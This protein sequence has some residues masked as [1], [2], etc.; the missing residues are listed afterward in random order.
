[1]TM[2]VH[3]LRGVTLVAMLAAL[4]VAPSVF[5]DFGADL[6]FLQK[7]TNVIVLG[8]AAGQAKLAVAPAWQGRVMTSTASGKAGTS[9]GWIN[10]ELIASGN[11]LPHINVFGGEDRYWIGPEGGQFSVFFVKGS[12]FDLDHWQTPLPVDTEPWAVVSQTNTSATF[13]AQFSLANFSG[14]K[15][16][17][18]ADREVRLLAPADAWKKFGLQPN[19]RVTLVAY[20]SENQ[21]TNVGL[22]PWIKET[23]LLSI[24]IL[25]QYNPST[26]TT[27]AIPI[28]SGPDSS[29]GPKVTT[30]YFGSIPPD[31]LIVKD[32]AIF[33]SGDGQYRSK[34]GINPRRSKGIIGSYDATG[35]ILTLAQFTQPARASDYVNSLWKIQDQPYGGD[36]AM[37][38]NDGPS[39]PGAK[40]LGPFYELES[41]SPAAALAPG[42]SLT[43]VHRTVHFSGPEAELDALARAALGISL[44]QIKTALP[45]TKR[46]P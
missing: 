13:R 10:R 45:A 11:L 25:G 28:K 42:A 23:G 9:Y 20:E 35:K 21:I 44:E 40:P 39:S 43:H 46:A 41:N 12:T 26:T 38:Y 19:S 16:D 8:D 2:N 34:I 14:T 33:F 36:A 31:R 32:E 29:L 6:S 22:Q 4:I 30:E 18:R 24:W 37:S 5:A 27:V 3:S 15:F 17:V 1:M 7:H